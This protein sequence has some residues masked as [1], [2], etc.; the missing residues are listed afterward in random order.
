MQQKKRG[1]SLVEMVIVLVIVS[2]ISVIV[3]YLLVGM[4]ENFS[5]GITRSK[6]HNSVK[7][8]LYH[9]LDDVRNGVIFTAVSNNSF[10]LTLLSG[11]SVSYVAVPSGDTFDIHRILNGSG[12]GDKIGSHVASLSG[13]PGMEF[14][15]YNGE[16]SPA[17]SAA[18]TSLVLITLT[19]KYADTN[20]LPIFATGATFHP[21]ALGSLGRRP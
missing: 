10:T 5:T 20:V 1:F 7:T 13:S 9:I 19:M 16:N 8:I 3:V 2:I 6:V 18:T 12:S 11:D 17:L 21:R 15:Y 4:S 14:E